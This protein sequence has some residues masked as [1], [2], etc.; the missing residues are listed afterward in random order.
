MLRDPPKSKTTILG[1][2]KTRI[3][4]PVISKEN[5]TG[6]LFNLSGLD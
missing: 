3:D 5:L 1:E 6:L 2:S 4:D